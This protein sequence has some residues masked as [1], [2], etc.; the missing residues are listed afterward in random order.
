MRSLPA[1]RSRYGLLDGM[2]AWSLKTD[3][4][5]TCIYEPFFDGGGAGETRHMVDSVSLLR[6]VSAIALV[7]EMVV[8]SNIDVSMSVAV[9]LTTTIT[10]S[11]TES[12]SS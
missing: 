1:I 5:V 6:L 11:C 9:A 7:I 8:V 4:L 3:V 12:L 10:V 2:F